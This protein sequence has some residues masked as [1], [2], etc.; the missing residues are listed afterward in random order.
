M[1]YTNA[2]LHIHKNMALIQRV[3][4]RFE[5]EI[6]LSDVVFTSAC[7]HH[8]LRF[9]KEI[10]HKFQDEKNGSNRKKVTLRFEKEIA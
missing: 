5:R 7:Q 4:L 3:T 6:P 1:R 9:E 8:S 2:R 10:A